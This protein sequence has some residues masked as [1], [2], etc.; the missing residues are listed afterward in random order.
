MSHGI[1]IFLQC[2]KMK[3]L[4]SSGEERK[5]RENKKRGESPGESHLPSE[6]ASTQGCRT[7]SERNDWPFPRSREAPQS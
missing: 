5:E 6:R 1:D 3:S 7:H 2:L 4:E